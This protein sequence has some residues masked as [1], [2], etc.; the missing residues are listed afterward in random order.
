MKGQDQALSE[1]SR[2]IRA[3]KTGLRDPAQPLGVFLLTGP[4]GVGKTETGLA[5]AELLFGGERFTATVNMSEFQEK[6]TVSRL[7]G[8]PPGYVGYGEGGV[9]TE[10]V[11]QRPYSVV[12]LDE[13]EKANPEVLNLFYQVFDKGVLA[14]GEGRNISFRNSVIFM[15]SNLGA[16]AITHAF[17]ENPELGSDEVSSLVRPVL[18]AHF[19]PALLARMT[20]VPFRP[21][22][23]DTLK[24]IVAM[25]LCRVADRLT[26]AHAVSLVFDREVETDLTER[27]LESDSGARNIDH[28]LA[29]TL[30]PLVSQAVLDGLSRGALPPDIRI[31]SDGRGGFEIGAE[32]KGR[33][34]RRSNKTTLR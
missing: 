26:Q 4:S 7:I 2:I 29:G 20:V 16:D 10:A 32:K 24:D 11:R 25:K 21:L 12:L 8:S 17:R 3:S 5:T 15:T 33:K 22:S 14:D 31:V 18:A 28:L 9:L 23:R 6:H 27:C 1:I 19:K 30:L 13:A 34:K